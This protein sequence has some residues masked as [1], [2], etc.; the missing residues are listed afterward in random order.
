MRPQ[1]QCTSPSGS[2][3][4]HPTTPAA[5]PN[6]FSP[7]YLAEA[8][9][10]DESLTAAEAD[11]AGP[12]KLEPVPGHPDAVAVLRAFESLAEG[13][14]PEAVFFEREHAVACAAVLPLNAREPLFHL[15]ETADPGGLVPAGF[16]MIATHGE[17]GPRVCGW[18][19]TFNPEVAQSLHVVE[20]LSR[21]P[22]ALAAILHAA[23]GGA[24]AQIGRALAALGKEG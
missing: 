1:D 18:M 17:Q 4:S 13:D 11:L 22:A 16:P 24:L 12:W 9:D 14:I 20:G 7:E 2:T 10:R 5:P 3:P 21:S 8:H 15:A 6:A 23:G 19:R